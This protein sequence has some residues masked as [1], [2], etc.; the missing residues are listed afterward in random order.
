MLEQEEEKG[1]LKFEFQKK[2]YSGGGENDEH[3]QSHLKE[4]QSLLK[5][6]QLLFVREEIKAINS[7][8]DQQ[9]NRKSSLTSGGD[10]CSFY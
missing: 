6:D 8:C 3:H 5:K 10:I 7:D 9:L 2:F 1:K 4:P